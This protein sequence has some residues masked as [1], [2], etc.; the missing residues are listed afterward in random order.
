MSTHTGKKKINKITLAREQ[1]KKW[2]GRGG[3]KNANG[4]VPPF[5]PAPHLLAFDACHVKLSLC[6]VQY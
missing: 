6:T 2:E 3:K 1:A 4:N 5:F